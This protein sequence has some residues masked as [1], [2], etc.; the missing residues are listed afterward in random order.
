MAMPNKWTIKPA[1]AGQ[2][3]DVFLASKVTD[4]TRSGIAKRLKTGAGT[5]NAKRATVHA[6]LKA[7]D[8]VAFDTDTKSASPQSVRTSGPPS[9]QRTLKR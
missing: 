9:D 4:L 3:L 5:I 7:G 6:F 2:R 8:K 1:D